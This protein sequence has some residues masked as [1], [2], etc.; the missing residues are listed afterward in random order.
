MDDSKEDI[1][2]Y[3]LSLDSNRMTSLLITEHFGLIGL[4]VILHIISKKYLLCQQ[5]C[6]DTVNI[7]IDNKTVVDCSNKK[8]EVINLSDYAMLDKDL[9]TL[10]SELIQRL[11]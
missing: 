2:G 11:L 4:L 3:G 8:Q 7:L 10:I 1:N 6:F 5:E 9:W